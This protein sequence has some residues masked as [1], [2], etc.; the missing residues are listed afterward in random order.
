MRYVINVR[1]ENHGDQYHCCSGCCLYQ[2]GKCPVDDR[3]NL[4]CIEKYG[5]YG[6]FVA[7]TADEI[8]AYKRRQGE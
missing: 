1:R 6:I 7:A 5:Y 4:R 8:A 3:G 2:M